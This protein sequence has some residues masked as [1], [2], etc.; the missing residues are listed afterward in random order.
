M[1]LALRPFTTA[2]V[3]L[4]GAGVIAVSPLAPPPVSTS[5][6]STTISTAQV[7]LTSTVDPFT[8]L[9][10][11]AALT[12]ENLGELANYWMKN[13][14]PVTRQVL[15]NLQ[16][17]AGWVASGI[18]EA[19]PLLQARLTDVASAITQAGAL[20][21]AGQ[22]QQ[23]LT[24]VANAIGGLMWAGF[25]L[26][27]LLSIPNYVAQ[28]FTATVGQVFNIATMSSLVGVALG[29]PSTA[30]TSLGTSAQQAVDAFNAGDVAAGVS[31]IINTP[32]DVVDTLLNST[33]GGI[34]DVHYWGA[35]GC[36]GPIGGPALNLLL[37]LP[38]RIAAAIALPAT[39]AVNTSELAGTPED[40]HIEPSIAADPGSETTTNRPLAE[41][42]ATDSDA[43]PPT[44]PATGDVVATRDAAVTNSI[45][46]RST[47][48]A[49]SVVSR[50]AQNIR[51][52]LPEAG[53]QV[54]K[55]AKQMRSGIEKSVKKFTDNFSKSAK[56]KEPGNTGTP[57][58]TK[59]KAANGGA[60]SVDKKDK[61]GSD[62]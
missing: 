42:S 43:S 13:P 33:S 30:L 10:Q 4:V 15:S 1:Q 29:I 53:D 35:C 34:I 46:A 57:S 47:I 23:A 31:A 5:A 19:I 51:T 60:A 32:A 58:T 12:T 27:S 45:S 62:D 50:P 40:V 56:K 22:P 39:A 36:K 59:A 38:E 26:M 14:A 21:Q 49:H 6:T 16:T 52:S 11:V 9:E 61:P 28:H 8:R 48:E 41:T 20:I 54:G 17:Y 44:E 24:N 25:P 7:S 55:S 3:A 2:G 18:Q 37:K